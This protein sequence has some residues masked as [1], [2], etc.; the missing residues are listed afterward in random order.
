MSSIDFWTVFAAV[1]D[2]GLLL[3][4]FVWVCVNVSRRE[5][6]NEGLGAYIW[7]MLAVMG[8]AGIATYIA[9]GGA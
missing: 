5:Q 7:G 1:L 3:V 9:L 2:A 6:R 8:F 4:L